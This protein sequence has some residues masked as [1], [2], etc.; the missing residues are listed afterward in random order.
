MRASFGLK[1]ERYG[2]LINLF[3]DKRQVFLLAEDISVSERNATP[4]IH[5]FFMYHM[6]YCKHSRHSEEDCT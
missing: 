3:Y 2:A 6:L 5:R 4:S 1:F